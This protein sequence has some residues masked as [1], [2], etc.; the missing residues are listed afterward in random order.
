MNDKPM[1]VTFTP[2]GLTTLDSHSGSESP[3]KDQNTLP[4]SSTSVDRPLTS[5]VLAYDSSRVNS[6]QIDQVDL[7]GKDDESEHERTQDQDLERKTED[8]DVG[9][10]DVEEGGEDRETG[11]L[12]SVRGIII[13]GLGTTAQMIDCI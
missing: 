4:H 11:K 3:Y 8:H 12:R 6:D 10:G 5:T 9:E 1:P 13:L 2:T 7:Q